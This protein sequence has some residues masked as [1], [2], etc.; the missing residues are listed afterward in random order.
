SRGVDR[1]QVRPDRERKSVGAETTFFEDLST[2]DQARDGLAPL[3]AKVWRHCQSH[4]LHGRTVT[5]K[6]RFADFSQFT[7]RRTGP[8]IADGGQLEAISFA[9]LDGVFPLERNIRLLG[10]TLS[11]FHGEEPRAEGENSG[12]AQLSLAL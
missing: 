5:L 10:V 6:V 7:R 3:I 12:Q 8:D 2:L 4:N 1:R 9:L 11:G